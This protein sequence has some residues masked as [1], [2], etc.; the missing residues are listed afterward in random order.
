M[1]KKERKSKEREKERDERRDEFDERVVHL[2]RTAKVVKGG[3][4]FAFRAVVVVGDKQG[5][6]GVGIGKAREVPDAIRKASDRA[7]KTMVS[8]PRLGSTIPHEVTAK[9]GSGQVMLKPASP[10]TGVIAGGGVRAVV[11]AAGISDILSKS[12]GSDNILNVVQA[13]FVGLKEL[14]DFR[15]EAAYR[16]VDPAH[17]APFWYKEETHG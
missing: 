16:G 7:K 10:G 11:E 6:V 5:R 15:Q 4:R 9:F 13:T 17:L 1:A 14:Q 3:R 2:A 8:V 12:L